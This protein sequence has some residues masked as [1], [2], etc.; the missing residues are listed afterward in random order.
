M[1]V[2]GLLA[3][4][5]YLKCSAWGCTRQVGW[6]QGDWGQQIAALRTRASNAPNIKV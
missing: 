4:S 5:I 3:N 2:W 1:A 6:Q